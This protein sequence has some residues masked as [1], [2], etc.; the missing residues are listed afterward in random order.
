MQNQAQPIVCKFEFNLKGSPISVK[1][2]L[3]YIDIT[4]IQ[5]KQTA[6]D[7]DT[8]ILEVAFSRCTVLVAAAAWGMV[9]PALQLLGLDWPLSALHTTSTTYRQATSGSFS[10]HWEWGPK[11]V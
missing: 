4:S 2:K 8:G 6:K 5:A 1:F 9:G 11:S 3:R 10:S 7:Q